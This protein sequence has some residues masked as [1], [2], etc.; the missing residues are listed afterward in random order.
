MFYYFSD[1]EIM[2]PFLREFQKVFSPKVMM[3]W[4]KQGE[5]LVKE[6]IKLAEYVLSRFLNFGLYFL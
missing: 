5:K 2:W 3:D 4:E 6:Y 1:D